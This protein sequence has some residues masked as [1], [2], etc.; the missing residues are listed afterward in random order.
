LSPIVGVEP[1]LTQ[2]PTSSSSPTNSTSSSTSQQSIADDLAFQFIGTQLVHELKQQHQ[3][4]KQAAFF[5]FELLK[6]EFKYTTPIPI[7]LNANWTCE[8]SECSF[9]LGF[10]YVFNFRKH[11]S[12]ANFMVILPLTVTWADQPCKIV[13]T[14]SEPIAL[15]QEN[16][17]KLQV[18]NEKIKKII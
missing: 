3:Q 13:L 10:D 16:D 1:P 4:N 9:E 18:K 2:P 5:N 11:L 14:R 12:Q 6:Y 7:V 17:N 15:T 8:P